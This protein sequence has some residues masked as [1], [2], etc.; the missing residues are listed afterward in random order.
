MTRLTLSL[1]LVATTALAAACNDDG[2][3][4]ASRDIDSLGPDFAAAFNAGPNDEPVDAQ[5]VDLQLT[6]RLDPFDI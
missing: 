2:D 1:A 4:I 3:D 6:P 5:D